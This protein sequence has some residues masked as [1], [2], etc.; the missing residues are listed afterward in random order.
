MTG[1]DDGDADVARGGLTEFAGVQSPKG[2]SPRSLAG[3]PSH[4]RTASSAGRVSSQSGTAPSIAS[5]AAGEKTEAAKARPSTV[6]RIVSS[7][8]KARAIIF[9]M[10][11]R[12]VSPAPTQLPEAWWECRL[13]G[14][15]LPAEKGELVWVGVVFGDGPGLSS[16][17]TPAAE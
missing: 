8:R 10:L 17:L 5:R 1:T 7:G 16:S 4:S 12:S 11:P 6:T 2:H 9:S 15:C 3:R 13:S 14:D